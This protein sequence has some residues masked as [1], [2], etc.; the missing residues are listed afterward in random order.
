MI[1]IWTTKSPCSL[2]RRMRAKPACALQPQPGEPPRA[3]EL[4]CVRLLRLG[5]FGHWFLLVPLHWVATPDRLLG[6]RKLI[7]VVVRVPKWRPPENSLYHRLKEF[8]WLR[9]VV[10]V[11][12][13]LI[14]LFA[15]SYTSLIMWRRLKTLPSVLFRQVRSILVIECLKD[16]VIRQNPVILRRNERSQQRRRNLTM[17]VGHQQL[18][19]VVQQSTHDGLLIGAIAV[20][21]GGCLEPVVVQINH[22]AD[23]DTLLSLEKANRAS[24]QLVCVCYRCKTHHALRKLLRGGVDNGGEIAHISRRFST[25]AH[26]WRML[27]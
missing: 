23:R 12:A 10:R 11:K 13:S 22:V 9:F 20:G 14:P 1:T 19:D 2:S 7:L 3:E 18:T 16:L 21:S 25:R 17:V 26:G 27:G 24:S 8:Q 5:L 15:K 6:R 4:V